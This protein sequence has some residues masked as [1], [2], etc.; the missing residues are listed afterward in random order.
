M[1]S[2]FLCIPVCHPFFFYGEVHV[3]IFCPFYIGFCFSLL[4][5]LRDRSSQHILDKTPLMDMCF[6]NISVCGLPFYFLGSISI[7]LKASMQ[8]NKEIFIWP[9]FMWKTCKFCLFFFK[10]NIHYLFI[11]LFIFTHTHCILFLQEINR[12]TPSIVNG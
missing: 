11:Y 7:E 2:I 4:L 5:R 1:L 12:L 3:Q 10:N 6:K 9:Q 8:I